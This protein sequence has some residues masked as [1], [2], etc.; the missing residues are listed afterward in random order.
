[1]NDKTN[2]RSTPIMYLVRDGKDVCLRSLIEAGANV[3]DTSKQGVTF[4]M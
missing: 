1:M 3:K 2:S 4:L